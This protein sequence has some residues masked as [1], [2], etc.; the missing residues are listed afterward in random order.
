MSTNMVL[1]WMATALSTTLMNGPQLA[2]SM[3]GVSYSMHF[4]N[5]ISMLQE[6]RT[7]IS[8]LDID[9]PVSEFNAIVNEMNNVIIFAGKTGLL[10]WAVTLAGILAGGAL[11]VYSTSALAQ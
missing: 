7:S 6:K 3:L 8:V 2:M 10:I 5:Y 4:Q 9:F 1:M 11:L